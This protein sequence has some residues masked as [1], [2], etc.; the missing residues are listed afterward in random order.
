MGSY[1]LKSI[2][3]DSAR[4]FTHPKPV[5]LL[6]NFFPFILHNDD[7]I[8]DF[9]AG[10]GTTGHAVMKLNKE[11]GGNRK[12]ILVQLP[13]LTD[14]KS[15][16]YKAG[17]KKISDITIERNR[18]VIARIEQ[19][20][21]EKE[22]GLFDGEKEPY[23]PGF[24][25]YRLVKS[26]FPRCEFV[27]DPELGTEENIA[28][29]KAYIVE[30][31][32]TLYSLF[33]EADIFDEVLLKNGFML[34]YGREVLDEFAENRVYRVRD[35]NKEALVCLDVELNEATIARLK[36]RSEIFI[37]LERALDT[38]K[39]WNLKHQLGERLVAF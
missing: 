35:G 20:Q 28:R 18:R 25:V 15:E 4:L 23:R 2:F 16:A 31:E 22:Q 38:T 9:F 3:P 34:N 5:A 37:C 6:S 12:C 13:E 39:K 21:T 19:E 14:E 36:G 17:Y 24:K 29:L 8:L 1:D 30:K 27:P 32:A 7:I 26:H 11:D 10:A 33:N